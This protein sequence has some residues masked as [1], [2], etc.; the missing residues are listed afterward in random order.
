[1]HGAEC[2]TE[3]KSLSTN[4]ENRQAAK[5]RQGGHIPRWLLW[6]GGVFVL[7]VVAAGVVVEYVVHHAEPIVRRRVIANL[8]QRFNSPVEL[9]ALHI[10]VLKG[11]QVTGEGLRILR[12]AGP[13]RP[14]AQGQ[15]AAPMLSV[16]SFEF[17]AGVRELFEPT[18]RL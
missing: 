13:E 7:L 12:V 6:A 17:R 2:G 4:A 14:D 8:E 9:D 15:V 1:M 5:K 3:G 18:M 16:K 11:L 10:S